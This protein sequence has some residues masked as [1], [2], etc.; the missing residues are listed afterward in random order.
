MAFEVRNL[1]AFHDHL[2]RH[3]V[4]LVGRQGAWSGFEWL[5]FDGPD[6]NIFS[7]KISPRDG[8]ETLSATVA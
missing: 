6:G 1:A 8:W 2:L 5:H 4:K 3:G 7:A